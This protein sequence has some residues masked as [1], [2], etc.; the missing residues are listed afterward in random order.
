MK[1]LILLTALV[2]FS[3]TCQ[4]KAIT[5][6]ITDPVMRAAAERNLAKNPDDLLLW[7]YRIIARAMQTGQYELATEL[8]DEALYLQSGVVS[9]TNNSDRWWGK[10]R[11]KAY[12]GDAHERSLLYFYR[13]ILYWQKGDLGNA[14]ACFR[15]SLVQDMEVLTGESGD[16]IT[17]EYLDGFLALRQGEPHYA[18]ESYDRVLKHWDVY[19]SKSS[20]VLPKPSLTTNVHIFFTGGT[21]VIK[22]A[23]GDHKEVVYY[24]RSSRSKAKYGAGLKI[25]PYIVLISKTTS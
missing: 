8:I 22:K 15:A 21:P 16:W 5:D 4:G 20:N 9:S 3:L 24:K 7:H 19:R 18:E 2:S 23:K 10:D 11:N 25:K 6:Y 1:I 13:A 17:S 14:R 12:L